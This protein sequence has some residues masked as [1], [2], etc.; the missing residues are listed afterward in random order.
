MLG[1]G[2]A[3]GLC[4]VGVVKA[5]RQAGIPIDLVGGVSMGSQVGGLVAANLT[6]DQVSSKLWSCYVGNKLVDLTFPYI[7]LLS[8]RSFCRRLSKYVGLNNKQIED[9]PTP[10]FCLSCNLSHLNEYIHEEGTMWQA[11]RASSSLPLIFPPVVTGADGDLL[12][13]GGYINNLPVD[14]MRDKYGANIVIAVD[15]GDYSKLFIKGYSDYISGWTILLNN[16]FG[17]GQ[18]PTVYELLLQ[19]GGVV[20]FNKQDTR[21]KYVDVMIAPA[22]KG[23]SSWQDF[24][25]HDSLVSKGYEVAKSVL[26]QIKKE[27]PILWSMIYGKVDYPI[28]LIQGPKLNPPRR[29]RTIEFLSTIILNPKLIVLLIVGAGVWKFLRWIVLLFFFLKGQQSRFVDFMSKVLTTIFSD[30][31]KPAF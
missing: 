31:A 10:Y 8:G 17:R 2:G 6:L 28:E 24:H 18:F 25:L 3:R 26:D 23:V 11:M 27:K 29:I 4:H 13:D 19:L 15:V 5:L 7:S 9:L 20:D 12:V 30:F 14:I 21:F 22:L 1:G 16:L